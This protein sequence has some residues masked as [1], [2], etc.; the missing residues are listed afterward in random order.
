V[1]WIGGDLAGLPFLGVVL[2]RMTLQD[3]AEAALVDAELDRQD[4]LRRRQA[5]E[6]EPDRVAD[7][8]QLDGPPRLWWEDHPELSERFRRR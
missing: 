7:P 1:L 5:A 8:A 4:E 3:A 6:V 2:R